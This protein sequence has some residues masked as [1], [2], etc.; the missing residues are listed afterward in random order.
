MPAFLAKS[1]LPYWFDLVTSDSERSSA[2]YREILEWEIAP[3]SDDYQIGRVQGLPVA[4]FI[5]QPEGPDAWVTYI[6]SN[7]L[8]GDCE[9]AENLGGKVLGE[10]REVELGKMV[11]LQDPVG[12]VFGLIRPVGQE[13]F[14]AGGEPGLPVWHEL[15]V[16]HNFQAALD[17]YGELFNW[18]I[19]VT[20]SEDSEEISDADYATAEE[21]G[22]PFAGFWN[23]KGS[24]PE[25]TPSFW[26]TYIGVRD[27]EAVAK[28]VEKHGGQILQGVMDSPFGRL[29]MV[30]DVT[31]AIV[32]FVE[33]EDAP[34]EEPQESDDL[35]G[36]DIDG[37]G[38]T[39]G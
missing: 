26:L 1:G 4:G 39:R 6:L 8:D 20:R 36:M 35:L 11:L 13:N 12:A 5:P 27:I 28:A 15:N 29:C 16:T 23:A 37:P 25:A 14:V 17:F 30:R 10:V 32:P 7:D 33:V 3:A 2:F 24:F 31:G 38:P 18:E 19:N 34:E 21:Q 22:A 9:R